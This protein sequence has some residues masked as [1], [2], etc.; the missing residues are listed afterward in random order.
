MSTTMMVR[1]S[2]FVSTSAYSKH[3]AKEWNLGLNADTHIT[4]W[5]ETRE[6]GFDVVTDE[7]LHNEGRGRWKI[8]E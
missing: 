6:E 7:D 2:F 5:L 1:S 8:I 4:A 3:E